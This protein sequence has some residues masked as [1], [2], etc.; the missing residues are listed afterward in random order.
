MKLK[1]YPKKYMSLREWKKL[2]E[3]KTK[4]GK[5][6]NQL[7]NQITAEKIKSKTSDAAI[8]KSFRLDE[9]I[10]GLKGKPA[11]PRVRKRVPVKIEEGIDYA[12][13]VDPYEDM[14]VEGLLNL[15]DYVPPQPEKQIAPKPPEYQKYPKYQMDPSYWELDPEEPPAYEDL[16]I[17]E[18][19]KA[20]EAPP[21]DDDDDDDDDDEGSGS[22]GEANKIL[23]HLE[24]PNYDDVQMRLDQPDMTPTKQR[25][26]LDKVVE[27]AERRR[28]QV[29]AFKSDAT[30]KFKK[31][32]IDAA[33]RDR[34]H[35][36]SDK[37]RLEINDYIKTYKFKSKSYKGYG[38]TKRQLG[39]GVYFFNDAKE[40][41]NK[42]TLIIG[43]MEA[44]NTSIQM[45]NMGVSILDALLKSE[46]I[47]KAQ[48]Q[49]LVK[50]YFKV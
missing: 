31:G 43:E 5:M 44:G 49:K 50:K 40:L 32:L 33:E 19:K 3:S 28:R 25:N 24:L 8:T 37:F 6:K 13:E 27:N 47:N 21:D 38:V 9:I 22:V 16:S 20:I 30:K 10:E 39:R 45:R 41:I 7:Y 34:I 14:D 17:A 12:P 48:Y 1:H 23:D 35:K 4:A 18:D 11:A 42:L 29:I 15:E 2:A 36:N 26:Y 46:S